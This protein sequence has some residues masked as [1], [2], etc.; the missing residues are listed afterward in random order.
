MKSRHEIHFTLPF[1]L[2]RNR[3]RCYEFV[4]SLLNSM[5]TYFVVRAS[6]TY[7]NYMDHYSVTLTR[8]IN[9][10][11]HCELLIL[12]RSTRP[13]RASRFLLDS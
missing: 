12:H 4:S 1:D 10:E 2:L 6:T 5:S 7:C 11:S 9:E 3:F 13:V 8:K